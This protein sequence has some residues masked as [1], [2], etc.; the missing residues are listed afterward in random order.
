M[1]TGKVIEEFTRHVARLRSVRGFMQYTCSLYAFTFYAV[2]AASLVSFGSLD[3]RQNSTFC[4]CSSPS[5]LLTGDRFQI[6]LPA[7]VTILVLCLYIH[8]HNPLYLSH[9]ILV[10]SL[11][12]SLP[13]CCTYSLWRLARHAASIPAS[14]PRLLLH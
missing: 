5:L 1:P 8:R 11:H 6:S 9:R 10:P 7:V 14:Q 2:T 3:T 13:L 12:Q 4:F